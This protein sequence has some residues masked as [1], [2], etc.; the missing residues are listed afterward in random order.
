M[1]KSNAF[2]APLHPIDTEEQTYGCRHTNPIIC[3]KNKMPDIC[4]FAR[5]DGICLAP[6]RSWL[7]QYQKLK[8]ELEN[9]D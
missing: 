7:K 6:P 2:H 9:A 8:Q 5:S 3:G 1:K 4:A